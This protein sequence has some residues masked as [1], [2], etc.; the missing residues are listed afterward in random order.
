MKLVSDYLIAFS[1]NLNKRYKKQFTIDSVTSD[2]SKGKLALHDESVLDSEPLNFD[3]LPELSK[4]VDSLITI[5]TAPKF[6]LKEEYD[7]RKREQ[8]NKIDA[9]SII[10]TVKNNAY[11]GLD[12]SGEGAT[13]VKMVT[14]ISEIYFGTYENRFIGMLLEKLVAFVNHQCNLIMSRIDYIGNNFIMNQAYYSDIP[15]VNRLIEFTSKGSK[16]GRKPILIKGE[17]EYQD[18]L[19]KLLK[20]R[21]LLYN[22]LNSEFYKNVSLAPAFTDNVVRKTNVF[23]GEVNYRRCYKFYKLFRKINKKTPIYMEVDPIDYRDY[24]EVS[25]INELHELGFKFGKSKLSLDQKHLVLKGLEGVNKEG[26]IC[27]ITTHEEDVEVYFEVKEYNGKFM[28][29]D[30][31]EEARTSKVSFLINPIPIGNVGKDQYIDFIKENVD[32][33]IAQGYANAFFV[34]PGAQ[35]LRDSIVVCTPRGDRSDNT[36]KNALASCLVFIEANKSIYTRVCP[37]C[38]ARYNLT[39]EIGTCHCP[40]CESSFSFLVSGTPK[41]SKTTLW[42]KRIKTVE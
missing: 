35:V 10:G 31:L 5:A 40:T 11:W 6:E 20:I 4:T 23:S 32:E 33:K 38:G 9:R 27:K 2:V 36:L 26:V 17:S 41:K 28:E 13:P 42:I 22:L 39:E 16:L 37:I 3:Y 14:K 15:E 19:T 34:T 8:V 29:Q 30:G 25:L 18:P 1:E 12:E 21:S 24:V 7:E